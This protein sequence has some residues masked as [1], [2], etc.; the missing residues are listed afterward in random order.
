MT[1]I[2][3]A[4]AQTSS[5]LEK[6]GELQAVQEELNAKKQQLD[7]VEAEL[8]S[9]R[10]AADKYV[11]IL[12]NWGLDVSVWVNVCVTSLCACVC[13]FPALD[14]RKFRKSTLRVHV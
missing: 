9:L 4:R 11:A 10:K 8:A 14:I 2:T 1:C 12:G 13:K 3:G 6:L 7:A 5:I